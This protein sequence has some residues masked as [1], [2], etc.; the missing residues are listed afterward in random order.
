MRKLC[1]ILTLF[2]IWQASAV[3]LIR[4]G[5]FEIL[6]AKELPEFWRPNGE[7]TRKNVQIA[8][9]KKGAPD[10]QNYVILSTDD[11]TIQMSDFIAWIQDIDL[12]VFDD[13]YPAGKEFLL[14]FDFTA[15][16]PGTQL[17]GY[18][19]GYVM[20]KS[21]N[22]IG[23]A[24]SIYVGWTRYELR[25]RLPEQ[26]PQ[27]MY[28]VLQLLKAGT[29]K[30]D[31]VSISDA[32]PA[33]ATPNAAVIEHKAPPSLNIRFPDLPAQSTFIVG[34]TPRILK[35]DARM[36][37]NKFSELLCEIREFD[38]DKTLARNRIES[39]ANRT[40]GNWE[41]P[42]LPVGVYRFSCSAVIAGS[43]CEENIV[44]RV[45]KEEEVAQ[46]RVQLREDH[47]MLKNGKPY[48]PIGVCPGH[49]NEAAL[50]AYQMAGINVFLRHMN[51]N[52]SATLAQ[53]YF[54]LLAKYDLDAIDWVN[55]TDS[56]G[57]SSE[58]I[59]ARLQIVAEN[60]K[61][62]PNFLGWMNDEDAWRGMSASDEQKCYQLF[63]RYLPGF[64]C[65]NNQAPRGTLP[66][67]RKYVRHTDITGVDVY[68]I[69]ASVR[70]SEMPRQTIACVG[71]Y[72]D[73]YMEISDG[74]K[75]VWMI[76]QAW[77]WANTLEGTL[78]KPVP[79]YTELRFMFYNAITH[80]A[81]GI[82]WFQQPAMDPSSPVM[83]RIAKVNHEFHAIK[84]FL[85]EGAKADSFSL[86]NDTADLRLMER[87]MNG[88]CLLILVNERDNERVASIKS[89]DT[90]PLYDTLGKKDAFV[91]NTT[92]QIM[93]AP[94]EVLIYCTRP[95]SFVAPEEFPSLIAE[96]ERIP[97]LKAI[98]EDISGRTLWNSR[99]FW[100]ERMNERASYSECRAYHEFEV[101]GEVSSAWLMVGADNF[102]EVYLNNH[103]LFAVEGW[104]YLKEVNIAPHL[105]A[106][107]NTLELRIANYSGF[108]GAIFEGAVET[109]SATISII[110]LEGATKIT[111]PGSDKLITPFFFSPA[112]GA[113]WGEIRR[114]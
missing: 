22:A 4:N 16:N 98:N 97:L 78:D 77:S 6:D 20:G 80:G 90:R 51:A 100:N 102:C 57:Q 13:S 110:P 48:F 47:Y 91:I 56:A 33:T 68:P 76:L 94:F 75:P 27:S 81:T 52:M 1:V 96:P 67:L 89:L 24:K 31:N 39:F 35:V 103:K 19:E 70:H 66:F 86:V 93:M 112:P 99:W 61:K 65:W 74:N 59:A 105:K 3:E 106:G 95:I 12:G 25:F 64:I 107:K 88:E 50:E 10:G 11:P 21:F 55:F 8:V 109:N 113:P 87:S 15:D 26:K 28:V 29:V 108:G 73:D 69:P 42:E 34:K 104:S 2:F 85:L 63:F 84:S 5:S 92:G 43:K 54:S 62:H 41:F 114:L 111:A 45:A 71:D 83:A 58:K 60:A 18:V 79:S 32:P 37:E 53:K 40:C 30:I 9:E 49:L 101:K 38:S 17:R 82:A 44:F 72:V 14:S 36:D 46:W 23:P 7:N